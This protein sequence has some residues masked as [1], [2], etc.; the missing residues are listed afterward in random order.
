ML[1]VALVVGGLAVLAVVLAED[2]D[3]PEP[4]AIP[5]SIHGVHG[6][7]DPMEF[8]EPEL[9]LLAEDDYIADMFGEPRRGPEFITYDPLRGVR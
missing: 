6:S 1:L 2:P 7:P 5:G 4:G 9:R 3:N 8:D